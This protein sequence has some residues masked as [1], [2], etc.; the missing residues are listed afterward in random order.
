MDYMPRVK[1][2]FHCDPAQMPF[3][4]PEII[5]S[6]APRAFFTNSPL[7]DSN[8][9][10]SG[11]RDCIDFARSFY[12]ELGVPKKMQAVYPDCGHDFPEESRTAA[13][14]FIDRWI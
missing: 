7:N 14:D 9:D 5:A 4:F 11:V 12:E 10:P 13:Y 8:F 6:L 3:D 1:S 2:T